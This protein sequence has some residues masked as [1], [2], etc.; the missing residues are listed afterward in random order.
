[1]SRQRNMKLSDVYAQPGPFS[2][3]PTT[4]AALYPSIEAIRVEI[5]LDGVGSY[6][7]GHKFVLDK[8][9]M[10]PVFDCPNTS[11]TRGG[12]RLDTHISSM[13]S[14]GETS[15]EVNLKCEGYEGSPKGKKFYRT[16]LNWFKVKI[17][18]QYKQED[19]SSEKS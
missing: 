14:A 8:T 9:T 13:V 1:M 15:K 2:G 7:G 17:S 5:D 19:K 3:Q 16:C 4:F 12:I 18:I 6:G 11:C 10:R